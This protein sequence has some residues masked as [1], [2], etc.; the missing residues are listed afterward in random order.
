MLWF[1][2]A[3]V[4]NQLAVNELQ[5][6]FVFQRFTII[7][8]SRCYHEV[9]KLSPS[10]YKSE[11]ARIRRTIPGAFPSLGYALEHPVNVYSLVA[12]NTK[13]CAVNKADSR[14][15]AQK[16]LLSE[17]GRKIGNLSLEF[18]ETGV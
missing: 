5:E 7:N 2:L 6:G 15:F 3:L 12:S 8:I 9:E 14:A 10:H 13:W 18:Y 1:F 11:T 17:Q 4:A 16:H